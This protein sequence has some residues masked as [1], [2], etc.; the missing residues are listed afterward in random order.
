MI[1]GICFGRKS[2]MQGLNL[3]SSLK[4][5]VGQYWIKIFIFWFKDGFNINIVFADALVGEIILS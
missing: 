5:C 4:H 3:K 1:R 2:F